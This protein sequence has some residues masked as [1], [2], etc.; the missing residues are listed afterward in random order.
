[1]LVQ[2][3]RSVP[4]GSLVQVTLH[5]IAGVRPMVGFGSVMRTLPRNRMGIHL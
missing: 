4:A 2:A 5:L 3:Q 1:M